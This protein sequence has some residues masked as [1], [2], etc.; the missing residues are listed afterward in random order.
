MQDWVWQVADSS[1]IDE[2]LAAYSGGELSDDERFTL[3]ETIIQSF[4]G[5]DERLAVHARWPR[6]LGWLDQSID[7]H[8][9]SVWYW[10]CDEDPIADGFRVTPDIRKIQA[11]HRS[12][13]VEPRML[14]I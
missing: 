7:V 3:M 10:S 6:V 14:P 5:L 9:Y 8:I 12:R 11:R 2:F 4:D 1:R 13:F